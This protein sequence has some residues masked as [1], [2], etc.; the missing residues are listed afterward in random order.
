VQLAG[1]L[2]GFCFGGGTLYSS[3]KHS[4]SNKVLLPIDFQIQP[5]FPIQ[6]RRIQ[7]AMGET[8]IKTS[9]RRFVT[10]PVLS[11]GTPSR[12]K[13]VL[14][15]FSP[16]RRASHHNCEQLLYWESWTGL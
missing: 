15:F 6:K 14:G 5:L 10:R 4:K 12:V 8:V 13:L 3:F 9:A 1:F 7:H 11:P 16:K 2:I